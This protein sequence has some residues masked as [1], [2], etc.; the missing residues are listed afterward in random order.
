MDALVVLASEKFINHVC[1]LL[2]CCL[3]YGA[4]LIIDT[5]PIQCIL[6]TF[7]MI[8]T[9]NDI[10]ACRAGLLRTGATRYLDRSHY[11]AVVGVEGVLDGRMPNAFRNFTNAS[12]KSP[13]A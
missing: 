12:F 2:I 8:Q 7:G 5:T 11:F 13:T 6:N 3:M 9:E 10:D 4:A 1:E